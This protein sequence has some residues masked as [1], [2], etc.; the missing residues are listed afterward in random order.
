MTPDVY[1]SRVSLVRSETARLLKIWRGFGEDDWKTPSF[2]PGW[3]AAN[4]VSHVT[5]GAS[6][7]ANSVNR[8]LDGLPPEPLYGKDAKEFH[9][10]RRQKGEE[11]MALPRGEMMDAFDSS[12]AEVQK[13]LE[14]I[15]AG[16]LEKLGYHPRG[17][18]RL[19]AWIGLR[20]VE[21]VVHDWDIRRGRDSSARVE[22][23]GVEGMLA[24]IP[25]NQA[26]FFGWREKP[27]FEGRFLF[28]SK[29]PEAAW[30]LRVSGEK[31]EE[32]PDTAGAFDAEIGADGEAHL[33]L[34]FG[35]AEREAMKKADRL[36]VSGNVDLAMKLLDVL[37]TK[38]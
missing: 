17:L 2:C 28:R 21:M 32:S 10:L 25:A 5:T 8:A 15:Q 30:S 18:V 29:S 35:R 22:T 13:A 12:A 20:L 36:Q 7:Y 1:L 19:D 16:D 37:Y 24:F 23:Q 11:L 3:D 6:F 26:R 31:A 14:R 9:A 34:I 33:L 38:Y 4:V 27:P